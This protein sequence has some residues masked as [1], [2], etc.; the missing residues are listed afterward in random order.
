M[1]IPADRAQACA[2]LFC[3]S[4]C[5]IKTKDVHGWYGDSRDFSTV[6]ECQAACISDDRCVAI[7]WDPSN[8]GHTCWILASRITGE[9][10]DPGFVTHYE[11]NRTCLGELHLY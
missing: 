8:A 9:T 10:L 6:D 2:Y 11:L 7:D 3:R 4:D 5:W 1:F